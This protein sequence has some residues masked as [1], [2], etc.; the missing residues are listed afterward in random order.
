MPG[1]TN[2]FLSGVIVCVQVA[3]GSLI[4]IVLVALL[5]FKLMVILLVDMASVAV[6]EDSAAV[7]RATKVTVGADVM[8]GVA[9][10]VF[11]RLEERRATADR[12]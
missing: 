3:M 11:K 5:P 12:R 9:D 8:T 7:T 10:T 4:L 2:P 6:V 1:G